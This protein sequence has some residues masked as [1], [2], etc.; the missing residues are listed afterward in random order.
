MN[1]DAVREPRFPIVRLRRRKARA[2]TLVAVYDD[3]ILTGRLRWDAPPLTEA[4]L[5][6]DGEA[7][8]K[9]L[10][11]ASRS[12]SLSGVTRVRVEA[13][14]VQQA[15]FWIDSADG[16]LAFVLPYSQAPTIA[17]LLYQR[18]PHCYASRRI[19]AQRFIAIMAIVFGAVLAAGSGALWS[20]GDLGLG[21]L[22]LF[23]GFS[24]ALALGGRF[25]LTPKWQAPSGGREA[26]FD[27]RRL[28][29]GAAGT[30][31]PFRS[32]PLGWTLR[33]L[34]I[35]YWLIITNE[36]AG[37]V[38]LFSEWH[39]AGNQNL[40]L[41]LWAPAPL[42]I[43]AGYRLCL[44]PYKSTRSAAGPKSVL[45][46]RSFED[47]NTT[48]LQPNGLVA[49]LS[50]L[51][52]GLVKTGRSSGQT[53]PTELLLA[54]TP[55]TLAR[56]IFG[57]GVA[58]SEE[59]LARFFESYGRVIAIGKPGELLATPGAARTYVS[60]DAWQSVVLD[61]LR[62]AYV[63]IVQPAPTS[64]MQWELIQLK[65]IV[66]PNRL[67]FSLVRYW[68]DPEAYDA[69]V[70]TI[71][72]TMG[73]ELPRQVPFL[74][75]PAFAVL[76]DAWR[77]SLLEVSY[78]SPLVWSFTGDAADLSYSLAPFVRNI[79]AEV[80]EPPRPRRVLNRPTAV[81]VSSV[82]LAVALGVTIA[83]G[84][85]AQAVVRPL[86]GTPYVEGY[87]AGRTARAALD[88][89]MVSVEGRAVAYAINVPASFVGMPLDQ[90][91]LEVA[92]KATGGDFQIQVIAA[93]G[94]EDVSGLP[95][96]RLSRYR[97]QAGVTRVDLQSSGTVDQG[98]LTWTAFRLVGLAAG[99]SR[100]RE[101]GRATSGP[102]GTVLIL[103]G[104]IG[105]IRTDAVND[106]LSE[107]IFESFV[108]KKQ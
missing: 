94:T 57:R 32:V 74:D 23:G 11:R 7:T 101:A 79:E 104:T 78:R 14:A 87:L 13:R 10:L 92:R 12:L 2:T 75:G 25:L 46:L 97:S 64:G 9:T 95:E 73:V 67:L 28:Q 89:P 56:M 16:R 51:R 71:A 8:L 4:M 36:S 29:R 24:I 65:Q 105:P 106:R 59:S 61:E 22:V 77:S 41:L 70:L 83:I 45:Y 96:M 20:S 47:D 68:D 3:H 18:F 99:G 93:N 107:R 84:F 1:A 55:I 53:T 58:T 48:S 26:L 33:V 30:K 35:V 15:R 37:I 98:G 90:P 85:A 27:T 6:P 66:P 69:L 102:F 19:L 91:L 100:F 21:P 38:E 63:V 43:Y 81:V 34:G 72:E 80:R 86:L 49:N 40:W 62:Q 76:D 103:I 108:L 52:M 50:G 42:L 88:E 82:G 54:Y 44:T 31:T 60:D 17:R 39:Q 5:A